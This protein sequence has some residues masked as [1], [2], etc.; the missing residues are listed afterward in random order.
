MG[1]GR[2]NESAPIDVTAS[3]DTE[4]DVKDR[5]Q[6]NEIDALIALHCIEHLH[7]LHYYFVVSI[8]R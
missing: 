2:G 3:N 7:R 5:R 6:A 4:L 1:V 8:S